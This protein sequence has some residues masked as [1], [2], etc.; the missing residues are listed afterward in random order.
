MQSSST[1]FFT[2]I[3]DADLWNVI[4]KF[5]P[6][7]DRKIR[8]VR[9][10]DY[11][12]LQS[13]ASYGYLEIL[14]KS[15]LFLNIELHNLNHK[16]FLAA[17]KCDNIKVIKWFV[18]KLMTT[19]RIFVQ[20]GE[21]SVTITDFTVP[22][23]LIDRLS[24]KIT[25]HVEKEYIIH[26]V[27]PKNLRRLIT[28]EAVK[29][30]NLEI[31]KYVHDNFH[32]I[33]KD[34]M[35]L[36]LIH[37]DYPLIE[38][39]H[40][41]HKIQ[42]NMS[43]ITPNLLENTRDEDNRKKY[44]LHILQWLCEN[45]KTTSVCF[46]SA[47]ILTLQPNSMQYFRQS[48]LVHLVHNNDPKG[49]KRFLTKIEMSYSEN[50]LLPST[51]FS[52]PL[53]QIN[54]DYLS[55]Y[56][57]HF[58]EPDEKYLCFFLSSVINF[59]REYAEFLWNL[60]VKKYI[61]ILINRYKNVNSPRRK[62]VGN[63]AATL[64]IFV[65]RYMERPICFPDWFSEFCPEFNQLISQCYDNIRDYPIELEIEEIVSPPLP[66]RDYMKFLETHIKNSKKDLPTDDPLLDVIDFFTIVNPPFRTLE[67]FDKLL[68]LGVID[69]RPA[70]SIP[71]L[72][73]NNVP[74][75]NYNIFR[76]IHFKSPHYNELCKI[77]RVMKDRII[78]C[79]RTRSRDIFKT[80]RWC[81]YNVYDSPHIPFGIIE[82][83]KDK[84][85]KAELCEFIK[86]IPY[87]KQ[88][89]LEDDLEKTIRDTI[90]RNNLTEL[91]DVKKCDVHDTMIRA[92]Q[93]KKKRILQFILS[94][95]SDYQD[96]LKKSEY[97][98]KNS[99]QRLWLKQTMNIDVLEKPNC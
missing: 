40:R 55:L 74:S 79:L 66:Y 49:F 81:Y 35:K 63:A 1:F 82:S 75:D 20:K 80:I 31:V 37:Y 6:K 2:L 34:A 44:S 73:F 84:L 15:E 78:E 22:D 65:R 7:P 58:P 13:A 38:W 96:M 24:E 42:L 30:G 25:R 76:C 91:I 98:Q 71:S 50:D 47:R 51:T 59:H 21:R 11:T 8:L 23:T 48:D 62:D 54:L 33:D 29:H 61:N 68:R 46:E 92:I 28:H 10:R 32:E 88:K 95:N 85:T 12:S 26:E 77:S 52:K 64:D 86:V 94:Q 4:R 9:F 14:Q 97:L 18:K 17:V 57:Q 70:Y 60:V 90:I 39:M 69:L 5:T 93:L 67:Y 56:H 99:I 43:D 27:T 3:Q 19:L 72:R 36:A 89:S 41:V 53:P 83:R 45:H 87:M 16:I